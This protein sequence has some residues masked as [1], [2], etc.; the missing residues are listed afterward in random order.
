M[1]H[2]VLTNLPLSPPSPTPLPYLWVAEVG[3]DTTK[4][5]P[6][7][8][9]IQPKG[10][11]QTVSLLHSLSRKILAQKVQVAV[12]VPD[13]AGVQLGHLNTV[14]RQGAGEEN[15]NT[16]LQPIP[17]NLY[18]VAG[19]FQLSAPNLTSLLLLPLPLPLP[20]LSPPKV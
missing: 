8:L 2:P 12:R 6:K 17:V 5:V 9:A 14:G 10:D 13:C 19:N 18:L 1:K 15:K 16:S 7:V 4:L 3:N 11:L 20:C